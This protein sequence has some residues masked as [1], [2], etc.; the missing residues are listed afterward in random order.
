MDK[1]IVVLIQPGLPFRR[2]IRYGNERAKEIGAEIILLTVSPE[3]EAVDR[4]AFANYEIGPY[5]DVEQAQRA[6]VSGFFDKAVQYCRDTG[7]AVE[8]RME[9]GGVGQTIRNVVKDKSVKMVVVPTPTKEIQHE[10]FIDTLR[11]FAHNMLEQEL[12]CP[13]VSVLAT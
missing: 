12:F 4:M 8:T 1:K 11:E 3:F 10:A 5:Q 13:V 7:I 2:T 9:R 6:D